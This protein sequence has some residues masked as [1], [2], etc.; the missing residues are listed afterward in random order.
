MPGWPAEL[1]NYV[2]VDGY[3]EMM[4]ENMIL[5]QPDMGPPKARRRSTAAMQYIQAKIY[6]DIDQVETFKTFYRETLYEGALSFDWEHP[7]TGED[8]VMRFTSSPVI[9]PIS[10]TNFYIQMQ[11]GILP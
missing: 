9:T 7:R 8:V 1:P 6:V 2:L 5:S 4:P 11:L 3:V 10:G